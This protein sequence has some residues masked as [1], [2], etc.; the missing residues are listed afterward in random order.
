M[1]KGEVK[2]CIAKT[3]RRSKSA[4]Y[5]KIR[6]RTLD[7]YAGLSRGSMLKVTKN[8]PDFKRFKFKFTNKLLLRP[9]I[10][11]EVKYFDYFILHTGFSVF[12]L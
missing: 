3:F 9:V 8:D 6:S 2:K 4:G 11:R 7:G 12:L 5:K 1:K 10:A